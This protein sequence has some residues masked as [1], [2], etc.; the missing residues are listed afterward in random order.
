MGGAGQGTLLARDVCGWG[1]EDRVPV[2]R[3]VPVGMLAI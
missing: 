1:E 2:G 3:G